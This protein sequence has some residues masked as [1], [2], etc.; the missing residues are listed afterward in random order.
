MQ[1]GGGSAVHTVVVFK[2]NPWQEVLAGLGEPPRFLKLLLLA[3]S[4]GCLAD[5]AEPLR[6]WVAWLRLDPAAW[7]RGEVWRM[8]TYGLFGRGGISAWVVL[9]LVLVYWLVQQLVV[10]VRVRRARTILL[11]GVAVAGVTA[12]LAQAASNQLGGPSCRYAPFWLMQGQNV[13]L[14]IG[15]AAFAANN[16][17]STV[18]HTPYVFGL[19]I[20]TKW[21]VPLHLLMTLGGALST[22]DLGGFVGIVA[23]TAWGWRVAPRH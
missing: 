19:P 17:H 21:L 23:A 6:P 12:A 1:P 16:R 10:W 20:P 9:Q 13:I 14:A 15:L 3:L 2:R 4:V 11:G 7:E 18:S 8:V 22:G 5:A